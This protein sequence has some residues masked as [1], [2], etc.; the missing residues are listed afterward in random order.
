MNR[1]L[2]GF[3][4]FLLQNCTC[5]VCVVQPYFTLRHILQELELEHHMDYFAP[6]LGPTLDKSRG[7]LWLVQYILI[8]VG[9][10]SLWLVYNCNFCPF[11][12]PAFDIFNRKSCSSREI[13]TLVVDAVVGCIFSS[14]SSI[15]KSRLATALN[16]TNDAVGSVQ[17]PL[18]CLSVLYRSLPDTS[19]TALRD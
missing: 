1:G 8:S 11:E 19:N 5:I 9:C 15:E 7:P 14:R 10:L 12:F 4:L 3:S 17:Y 18:V 2:R 16:R 13:L 6:R